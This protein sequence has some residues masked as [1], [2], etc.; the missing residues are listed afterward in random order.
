MSSKG[1]HVPDTRETSKCLKSDE[2]WQPPNG[3]FKTP[4]NLI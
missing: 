2:A 4:W 3:S 1:V